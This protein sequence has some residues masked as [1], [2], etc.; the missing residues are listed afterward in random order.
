MA[1]LTWAEAAAEF[2]AFF[3]NVFTG[4][5]NTIAQ[6]SAAPAT[7][8]YVSLHNADPGNGGSQT[9]SETAYTN[10]ARQAVVRTTAGWTVTTGSGTTFTVVTNAAVITFPACGATGDTLTHWGLGLSLSGAGTLNYFGPLGPTA[11]PAVPFGCTSASPGVLTHYGYTP[12]V[13][14]RVSVYQ[15]PGSEGLPTGL[16]EGTV[17]FIGTAPGGQTSTLSTTTANGN[18]VN[19]STTG[20]GYIYKQSPLIVSNG[21][22]PSLAIGA[23]S[24]QKA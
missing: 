9:T 19:T 22:T 1:I 10:Y 17:Y 8:I 2:N 14:D 3:C 13:N 5:W 12:T 11:G 6:N 18:P 24:L 15:G 16:T 4:T 21:I 23:I 7:N 20:S